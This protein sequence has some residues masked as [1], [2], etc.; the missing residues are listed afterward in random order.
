MAD[1]VAFSLAVHRCVLP[2]GGRVDEPDVAHG[3]HEVLARVL[4][5]WCRLHGSV[6][7]KSE[8]IPQPVDIYSANTNVRS[9]P[10][11]QPRGNHRSEQTREDL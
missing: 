4:L 1:F 11:P 2:A 7:V 3:E 5:Y 8:S 9:A 10:P 6:L